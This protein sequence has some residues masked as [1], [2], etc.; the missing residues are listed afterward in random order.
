M[1][2]T[3]EERLKKNWKWCKNYF[4]RKSKELNLI[5]WNIAIDHAKKRLG[6]TDY[7]KK[8]ITVSKHFLRGPTCDEKK[9]RNTVLHEIAHALA[10]HKAAHGEKWKKIALK[11]GCNGKICDTMDL[12]DAKWLMVCPKNCFKY[13]YFRKPKIDNKICLKCKSK[14][15]LKQLM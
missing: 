10:G 6:L 5:G 2:I 4:D 13:S 1:S 12:P 15:I 8:L 3:Y 14:P 7:T 11:I 9:I